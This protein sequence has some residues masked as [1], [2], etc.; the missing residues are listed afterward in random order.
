MASQRRLLCALLI[1]VWTWR[2]RDAGQADI[3]GLVTAGRCCSAGTVR[4]S[5]VERRHIP[6]G[7]GRL[8]AK[9]EGRHIP[10][11]TGRL[12]AKLERRHIPRGTGR[13][14]AYSRVVPGAARQ[15]VRSTRTFQ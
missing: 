13:L 2:V 7:T 14:I 6:G 15:T 3:R 9:V 1:L 5:K 4:V 11:G 8:I 10:R 12:I